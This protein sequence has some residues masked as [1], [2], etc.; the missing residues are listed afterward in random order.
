MVRIPVMLDHAYFM[1]A[2]GNLGGAETIAQDA[3]T[4]RATWVSFVCNWRPLSPW[5]KFKCARKTTAWGA[6]ACW[7]QKTPHIPRVSR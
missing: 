4:R 3:L 7:K 2:E 5:E 1:A 6:N